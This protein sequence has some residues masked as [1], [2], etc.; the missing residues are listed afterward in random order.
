MD[1]NGGEGGR[2]EGMIEDA[3]DEI[4]QGKLASTVGHSGA[5]LDDD[6]DGDTFTSAP[7]ESSVELTAQFQPLENLGFDCNMSG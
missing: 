3:M 7:I 6:D 4:E 5:M 1:G 2:L